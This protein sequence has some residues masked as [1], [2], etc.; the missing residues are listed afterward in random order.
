MSRKGKKPDFGVVVSHQS[1][2]NKKL[3]YVGLGMFTFLF[4]GLIISIIQNDEA[5]INTEKNVNVFFG[6]SFLVLV[7]S[8]LLWLAY[9]SITIKKTLTIKNDILIIESNKKKRN[10][11]ANLN[12]MVYW[13]KV[14]GEVI[15]IS[16][17]MQNFKFFINSLEMDNFYGIE[18]YLRGRFPKKEKKIK[19]FF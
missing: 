6:M 14:E 19:G 1:S 4:L 15:G 8:T 9:R 12:N 10:L 13:Q 17:K 2:F 5:S 11:R 7:F 18:R 3:G 16:I